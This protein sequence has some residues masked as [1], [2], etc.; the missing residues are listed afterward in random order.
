MAQDSST[1]NEI[2]SRRRG[3]QQHQRSAVS[4]S[5]NMP[6]DSL[7]GSQQQAHHQLA[8]SENNPTREAQSPSQRQMEEN[9][10]KYIQQQQRL[11]GNRSPTLSRQKAN[12]IK[13]KLGLTI[14]NKSVQLATKQ[15]AQLKSANNRPGA[16][17]NEP[18]QASVNDIVTLD[19]ASDSSSLADS[20][21][22]NKLL[23]GAPLNTIPKTDFEC[24]DKRGKFVSGLFAD[25]KTGCQ[26]WHLCSN[27]RKYSFL[28]P[29]GTIF[30][31][32]VRICD[33][34]YNVK[35]E[36]SLPF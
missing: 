10:R 12:L 17:Y 26:V 36:N 22:A 29:A 2:F 21:I 8:A 23:I 32:K 31:A 35:C 27:N 1:S 14:S 18:E 34:R 11:N 33:W 5:N 6:L 20:E 25:H 7:L 15:S 9:K 4:G 28:C 13:A 30:N 24:T 16:N 3:L 19:P